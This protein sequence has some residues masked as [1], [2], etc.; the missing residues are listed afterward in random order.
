MNFLG[1]HVKIRAIERSDMPMLQEWANDPEIQRLIGGWHFPTSADD[2]ENWFAALNCSSNNQRFSIE[3]DDLGLIGTTNLVS[4]DWK[5]RTAFHGTLIGNPQVRGK[6]Y[7]I[8]TI[9]AIMRFAFDDLGLE[10]LD[11]DI[12]EYNKRSMKTYT[13]NCGWKVHGVRPKWYFR[14]GQRWDK[15]LI[16]ISAQDYK[17]LIAKN[18]YW[19]S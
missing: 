15:V 2:Q 4:I 14:S 16:G 11:S 18:D 13:K 7:G 5:N 17:Q 19:K 3:T 8:D 9:M 12:I 10:H 6:G 1:K